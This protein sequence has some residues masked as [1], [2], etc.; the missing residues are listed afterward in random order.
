MGNKLLPAAA[1][2][3]FGVLSDGLPQF[4]RDNEGSVTWFFV[5]LV[6]IV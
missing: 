1:M 2:N 5:I 4:G 3:V 6:N